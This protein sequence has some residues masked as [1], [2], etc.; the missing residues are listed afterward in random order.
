MSDD[1]QVCTTGEIGDVTVAIEC[2]G[3]ERLADMVHL[4]LVDRADEIRQIVEEDTHP[5]EADGDM[6]VDWERYNE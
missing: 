5:D 6:R 4:D 2:V 1:Y 3:E